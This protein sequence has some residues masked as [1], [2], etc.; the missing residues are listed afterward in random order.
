MNRFSL[1]TLL[2]FVL[3]ACS[4]TAQIKRPA[5]SGFPFE[6]SKE[7]HILI[8]ARINGVE[9]NFIFDTGAGLNMMT[10]KFANKISELRKL[11]SFYTGHRATG[12]A[13][14]VDLWETESFQVGSFR[15]NKQIFSILDMDFPVDGLIS[16][17]SFEQTPITVDYRNKMI[18]I[19]T[20]KTMAQR[21]KQGQS[22]PIQLSDHRGWSLDIFL[23]VRLNNQ[24]TLQLCLDSGAGSDVYRFSA[25][26]MSALQVDSLQVK[27]KFKP[28][29]F[30]S[31]TG[32]N[33]YFTTLKELSIPG[34][35]IGVH[36]F[37]VTFIDH[38][39][40][41]GITSINWLGEMI[42]I[43]I[44]DKKLIVN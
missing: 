21:L 3:N 1:W 15:V 2:A 36:D 37:K 30:N 32:N 22:I 4:L 25:N 6:L 29:I 17:K 40:Y 27:H 33:Y 24:L 10:R 26:H 8:H 38:L 41:D 20:T 9:G 43:S 19:E 7:G 18:W 35:P 28:S 44:P 14:Q 39:L 12:E 13:I 11:D 23:F 5:S 42:T 31:G 34:T 16:L